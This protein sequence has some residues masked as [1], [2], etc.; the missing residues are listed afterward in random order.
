MNLI[1][2]YILIYVNNYNLSLLLFTGMLAWIFSKICRA[3]LAM[4]CKQL[5]NKSDSSILLK[6]LLKSLIKFLACDIIFVSASLGFVF[7]NIGV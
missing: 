7:I 4:I 1:Y 5:I 2:F 3:R 6:L